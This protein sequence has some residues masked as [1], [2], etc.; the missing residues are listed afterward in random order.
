MRRIIFA[1]ALVALCLGGIGIGTNFGQD[2]TEA[3]EACAA[4]AKEACAEEEESAELDESTKA[5]LKNFLESSKAG[6]EHEVL[7]ELVGKWDMKV[8]MWFMGAEKPV[9]R[10]GETEFKSIFDGRFVTSE[11]EAGD[12]L[13]H[14]GVNY[15]GYD[16]ASKR[17][18]YLPLNSIGTGMRVY[19]GT[20]D[21][22]KKTLEFKVNYKMAFGEQMMDVEQRDTWEFKE[23]SVVMTVYSKYPGAGMGEDEIKEIEIT[24]T[25]KK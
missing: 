13:P 23:D 1:L 5:M 17:Y 24:Y 2:K 8:K 12:P 21:A 16:K 6:K 18:Q 3:K 15:M 22:D 20:Y 19:E 4:D 11:Y 25:K 9:I 7:K 14:K 10:K